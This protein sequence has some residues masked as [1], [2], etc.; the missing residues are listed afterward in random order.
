M[1]VRKACPLQDAFCHDH[2]GGSRQQ[3]RKQPGAGAAYGAEKVT[4]FIADTIGAGGTLL[5]AAERVI[6]KFKSLRLKSLV[7][8]RYGKVGMIKLAD[9][10]QL[11]GKVCA[12]FGYVAVTW[13]AYNGYEE[14][15]KG[16]TGLAIVHAISALAGGALVTSAVFTS[17]ALGPAG[18]AIAIALVLGSAIYIAMRSRDDIQKWLAAIWWRQIPEGESEVPAI[19]PTMQMEMSQLQQLVGGGN[20]WLFHMILVFFSV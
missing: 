20:K 18:L 13:D 19:W 15:L 9:R 6:F 12:A 7:R 11:A 5:D 16:N 17:L 3:I 1:M 2:A 10:I 8:L 14:Y 4:K